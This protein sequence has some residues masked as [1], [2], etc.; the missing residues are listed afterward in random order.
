MNRS[1]KTNQ[2][3]FLE[4]EELKAKL[5]AAHQ[6]LQEAYERMQAEMNKRKR[7]EQVLEERLRFET[8]LA[9]I[10]PR[11]VNVL[12]SEVDREIEDA[13]RQI[14]ESL[15]LDLLAVWQLSNE[16]PVALMA[17]HYFTVQQ[18][19]Q[20]PGLLK[21]EDFPWFIKQLQAGRIV[22]VSSLEEM[23]AEAAH[24]REVC[25][26]LGVKSNLSI[27]LSL[28]GGP[29]IG[30]LGLNT[31][32]AER[33]WPDALVNQLQLIGQIFTNALARK[34]FELTLRESEERLSVTADSADVGLWVLDCR[35]RVFWASEKARAIFGYSADQIISMGH[36][37][38]LVHQDDWQIVQRSI[39]RA[40]LAGEPV[41]VEYRIR[42]DDSHTRWIAS[43]GR[44]YFTPTGEPDRLMGMS[45]DITERK[46]AEQALEER[47][48][49]ETLLAETSSRFVNVPTDWIDGEIDDAQRRICELLDL[50]RS[51][52]WHILEEEPGT[53]ALIHIHQPPEILSPPERMNA[54]DFFP[55]TAQKV[56]EGETVVISKMTDLPPEAGR[57]LENFRTYGAKSGVFVPL[58]VG[59]GP[60]FGLLGFA[61][62]REE[63]SWPETVVKGFQLVAQVFANALERKRMEDQLRKHLRKIEELKEQLERENVYLQDE[64]KLLVE[65]SEIVGQSRAIKKILAQAEQVAQTEA[66]VLLLGETGTGKE[67]LARAIHRMSLRKDRPLVTVSCASLP[68]TLIESELFGR[69]KGAYTGALTRMV[70]RFELADGSTLFLDEI[71]ELPLDL[72]GKLLRVLE[73]G[74]FERLGSSKPLHVDVRIIAATNRD[75]A[76][77]VKDGQF[78]RDLF[79]RLNVFPIVIPPLRERREDIPLL[80]RAMVK[81]FQKKMGKEIE[82]IPKRTMQTLQAYSWPGNVRELRN[83]IE[84][85]MILSKGKTLN[86]YVP[87]RAPSETEAAGNL[88][89]VERKHLVAVLEKTGWRIAGQGGAAE[90][91]GLKRT[92]LQAKMKKLGIKRSSKPMPK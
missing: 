47:L 25:R 41:N 32:R 80:V 35:T 28:G 8:L 30:V 75:I 69:E 22:A 73:E 1:N 26:L 67:L 68:P 17:T 23:P 86:V 61:I 9:E 56:L 19:P 14:C 50:D 21:Q 43:R 90:V 51:T 89:D 38:A 6:R 48:R 24:D 52:L 37:E 11:F 88:E 46:L 31:T 44:P 60:V 57:D 49:F 58:S 70:G 66:T 36:F 87:N 16:D 71:G 20:P 10:S 91:L 55:W 76:R 13:Q 34:R 92:T 81:E 82:S 62:V 15:D 65:H 63:R 64:V 18:G 84:H 77:A 29:L 40:L 5:D 79:Y 33:N 78:R 2:Q 72:Q 83:L 74:N 59:K 12:G 85:A 45:V 7:A 4:I 53:L 54:P 42:F 3:L 39:E 27:P